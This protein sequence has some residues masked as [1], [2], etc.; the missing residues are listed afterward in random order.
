MP[1]QIIDVKVVH[2]GWGRFLIVNFRLD[3]G[4]LIRR[5][6]EDHGNAAAVLPYDPVRRTALLVRQFRAPAFFAMGVE[7]TLEVIAGG[8]GSEGPQ[9]G[10]RREAVEEAGLKIGPL[11]H[12][13][14][15][16]T[17]PGVSTMRVDLYLATYRQEDRLGKGGGL[18]DER[19]NI[20]VVEM[21]LA[22]VARWVDNGT[23]VDLTTA[24][25]LQTLRFRRPDLFVE[26]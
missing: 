9:E 22:A 4:Q 6:I 1:T 12:V 5:E 11:D 16:L 25:L 8:I 21:K 18:A 19:E 7:Q 14:T 20:T 23:L 10:I 26:P 17:M 15:G 13:L 3:D 24:F 2:E